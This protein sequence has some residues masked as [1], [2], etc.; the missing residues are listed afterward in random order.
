MSARD[1]RA[2]RFDLLAFTVLALAVGGPVRAE[3]A[4][5]VRDFTG[6]L[7]VNT[8]LAYRNTPYA[9]VQAVVRMLR[10]TGISSVRDMALLPP[11]GAL[12]ALAAAGIK[13]TLAVPGGTVPPPSAVVAYFKSL[14]RGLLAS[15]EGMNE[16]NGWPTTYRGITDTKTWDA[17]PYDFKATATYMRDLAT[18]LRADPILRDVPLFNATLGMGKQAAWQALGDMSFLCPNAYANGHYYTAYGDQLEASLP[19]HKATDRLSYTAYTG[20]RSMIPLPCAAGYVGTEWGWPTAPGRPNGVDELTQAK[21]L[22]NGWASLFTYGLRRTTTG[23]AA[24]FIYELVDEKPDPDNRNVQQHYGLFRNDLT[25]KPAALAI[26]RTMEILAD[27]RQSGFVPGSLDYT[28]SGLPPTGG[29]LLLQ[30][31]SGTFALMIW[32]GT[33]VYRNGP[34]SAEPL[35]ITV[36]VA[37]PAQGLSVFDPMQGSAAITSVSSGSLISATLGD[38]PLIVTIDMPPHSSRNSLAVRR[39]DAR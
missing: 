18:A 22:L 2:F 3:R 30:K 5:D 28:V 20:G 13:A 19:D 10:Q 29:T 34:V 25:S 7:G 37:A 12:A 17:G 31:S 21:L 11:P 6:A 27:N 24:Q 14:P 35:P 8:H 33:R 36:S 4:S 39:S 38:H 16:V 9:D 26:G 1:S 15:I 23:S 32:P